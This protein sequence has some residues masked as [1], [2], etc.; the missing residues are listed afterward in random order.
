VTRRFLA[1]VTV[2][3]VASA[4]SVDATVDTSATNPASSTGP[5]GG[6][7]APPARPTDTGSPT[8]EPGPVHTSTTDG[9]GSARISAQSTVVTDAGRVRAE[10]RDG[11]LDVDV[12]P[13][14]GWT[15]ELQRHG[16]TEI[17]VVWTTEG[18]SV[19]ITVLATDTGISTTTRSVSA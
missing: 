19:R 1:P 6:E 14:S 10:Y 5:V 4:C 7:Q 8:T 9:S 2:L 13:H 16:P 17:E 12:D 15:V 11:R 18:R 3:V